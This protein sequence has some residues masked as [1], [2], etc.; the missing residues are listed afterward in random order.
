MTHLFN[1]YNRYPIE[2]VDGHDFHLVDRNGKEYVD[3]AAGIGVMS[4]GYHNQLI[5][6]S[7]QAQLEKVWHTSNL[8]EN[9]LQEKVADKLVQL[10]GGD[11]FV[12][13]A[14]SG[15]E[16]N[17]AALKLAHKYTGKAKVMTFTN[18]FHGRTYGSLAV[19]DYPGIKQG[20]FVDT[21]EVVVA[22]YNDPAAFDLLDDSF[23]AVI[24]EIVQGEGGVNLIDPDWLKELVFKTHDKHALVI[25]DEVQTGIGRTGKFFAFQHYGI[26]PDIITSAKALGSG[27][28]IGAMI[29]RQ[30]LASA[31]TPG[32][33]GTTFGGNMLAMAS[34]D[35]VLT[36]MTPDFLA[37]VSHKGAM[38][39]SALKI[40]LVDV[41]Q[42]LAIRGLGL[43]VGIQLAADLPVESII[44]DLQAAGYLT[45]SSKHNTL[46]LLPVLVID[47]ASL[48]QA[49]KKISQIIK[50]KAEVLA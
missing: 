6:R 22:D 12:F 5:Q 11:Q 41:D 20:F 1:T 37:D 17:E 30:E 46:R 27:L 36:Q 42:V 21:T 44:S 26:R 43:M 18:S 13:F 19:T 2:L 34:A 50:T 8:Y 48:L 35:A 47:E 3:L 33:H 31:F 29:G 23:A 14:N 16:A 39:I 40:G 38:L 32:S 15:T 45:I 24:V 4:F 10:S 49:A 9:S 7:V 25:I 28:P